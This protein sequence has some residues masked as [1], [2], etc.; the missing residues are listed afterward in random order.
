MSRM[1]DTCDE[2]AAEVYSLRQALLEA[3]DRFAIWMVVVCAGAIL[4]GLAMFI[5][6]SQCEMTRQ[7]M[8]GLN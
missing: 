3:D 5:A 1:M 6:G 8:E 7:V 4:F 2:L